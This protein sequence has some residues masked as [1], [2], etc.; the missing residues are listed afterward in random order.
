[1][2]LL[3]VI[4]IVVVGLAVALFLAEILSRKFVSPDRTEDDEFPN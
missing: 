2:P 4:L 3:P 1:M